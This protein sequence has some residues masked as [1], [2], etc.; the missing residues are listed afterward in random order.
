MAKA[1]YYKNLKVW[2]KSIDLIEQIYNVTAL[3]PKT[4]VYGLS[5]QLR[6]ASVSIASNIAE[7]SWRNTEIDYLRFLH[8]SK[9]SALEVDTQ[10]IIAKRLGYITKEQSSELDDM[11]IEVIKMI[12]GFIEYKR[13]NQSVKL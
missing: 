1:S 13:S 7:W 5:D 3:F 4:E 8:I 10:I 12:W 9:W 2:Q 11:I 6:R